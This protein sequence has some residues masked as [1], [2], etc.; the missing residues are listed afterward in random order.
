VCYGF[1]R[2][3]LFGVA[4]E[5]GEGFGAGGGGG[6]EGCVGRYVCWWGL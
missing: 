3:V 6:E 1:A 5:G 2:G 4:G